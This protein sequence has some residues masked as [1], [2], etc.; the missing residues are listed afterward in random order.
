VRPESEYRQALELIEAGIN[1]CEVSRRL[2]IP[3]GTIR[4][5][6][7]GVAY[8]SG[9]RTK[10]WSGQRPSPICFRCNDGWVDEEAYAY[11]LG[12]YLGDGCLSLMPKEVFRLRIV[13]DVR[14]PD[15]IDEIASSTVIIRGTEKVGFIM[16]TGCV[17]VYSDW[18]HWLCLFPQH[19]AGRKHER[20]IELAPWQRDIVTAHPRALVRGLIHSDGCRHINPI[21]RRLPSGTRHYRYTR[22]ML[23]NT[24]T[25]ILTIFTDALDLL[26]VHWTKTNARNIAVSRRDDVTFLDSFIGAKS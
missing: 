22:Y 24:S 16:K 13:C 17:E 20:R 6:R 18:K 23:T 9:G 3:R 2:G 8:G 12:Q 5:W 10:F 15:I 14:Y 26:E 11:L 19:G 21:T 7:V 4:D 1:D 25:D